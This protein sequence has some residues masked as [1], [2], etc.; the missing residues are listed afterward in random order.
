M[1]ASAF[2]MVKNNIRKSL[3]EQGLT[4]SEKFILSSNNQI[5]EKFLEYLSTVEFKK[6]LLYSPYKKRLN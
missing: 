3:L 5:Q 6:K 2:Y 4:L 1:I